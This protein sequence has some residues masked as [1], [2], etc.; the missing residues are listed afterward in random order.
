MA[1]KRHTRL[2][3]EGF[4]FLGV[5][6]VV[7]TA[8]LIRDINLLMVLFSMLSGLLLLNWRWAA[9]TLRELSVR[10]QVPERVSAGDPFD[11]DVELTSQRRR[12][13]AWVVRIEDHL[14]RIVPPLPVAAVTARLLSHRVPGGGLATATYRARLVD[15]GRYRLGPVSLSTRFPLGLVE[16]RATIDVSQHL[17]VL[18]RLGRLTNLWQRRLR[19]ANVGHREAER[20]QGLLEGEFHGLRDWRTGDSRRWI[21][22]RTSARQSALMVRQFEKQGHQ[23]LVLLVDPWQPR[24]ASATDR[25]NVELAVSLAATIIHELG[26]RGG[27]VV[28]GLAGR[29]QVLVRAPASMALVYNLLE[30]LAVLEPT[31]ADPLPALLASAL[32]NVR[33]GG[34]RVIVSTR[35]TQVTDVERF[36][37]VWND[38][39]KRPWLSR[40][41]C[42]D[43]S[44]ADI[45][46]YI[47]F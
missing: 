13:G 3:S 19:D 2:T 9:V 6:A 22:W 10:R 32:E 8:A 26:R 47:E 12:G 38:P 16:R 31:S 17:V 46:Q 36:Q 45:A 43:V 44:R 40:F 20:Q 29:Q 42:L 7:L 39:A 24:S 4:A 14:V 41:L 30:S 21:H 27:Q 5:L 18:P 34:N 15:R 1:R 33:Q 11:V 25:E 37:A 28:V 23:D 35:P